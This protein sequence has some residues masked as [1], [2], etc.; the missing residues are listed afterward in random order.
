MILFN[1]LLEYYLM[2]L[3]L[4]IYSNYMNLIIEWFHKQLHKN[5]MIGYVYFYI[6]IIINHKIN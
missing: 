1:L 3:I 5:Y 6:Y 2:N 4:Y